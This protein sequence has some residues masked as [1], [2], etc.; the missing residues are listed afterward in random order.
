M[1]MYDTIVTYATLHE[2]AHIIFARATAGSAIR[3]RFAYIIASANIV[4]I[5]LRLYYAFITDER[6][7]AICV[8]LHHIAHTT[9]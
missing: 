1:V 5:A 6:G 3:Y 7:N 8:H 4:E 9:D 2:Y